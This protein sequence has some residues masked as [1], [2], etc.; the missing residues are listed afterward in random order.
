MAG[1]LSGQ[2]LLAVR[3]RIV[4]DFVIIPKH[5]I[6]S[7]EPILIDGMSFSELCDR[8]DMTR[9]AARY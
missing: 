6:K 5:I 2:D 7:D 1:L 3:E 8:L 9:S 4:G